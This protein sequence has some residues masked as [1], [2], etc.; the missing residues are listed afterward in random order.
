LG[1]GGSVEGECIRC[2]FHRWKF[3]SDGRC[4]EVPFQ[5]RPSARARLHRWPVEEVDGMILVWHD[6]DGAEPDWRVQ[7]MAEG[8]AYCA[9]HAPTETDWTL[10]SHVQEICENAFDI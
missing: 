6:A 1:Y 2:P 3:D 4:V 10:R 7:P 8:D 9:P 5:Q